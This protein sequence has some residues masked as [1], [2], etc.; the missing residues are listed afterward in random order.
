MDLGL[1][2][3]FFL[4]FFTSI[5][6]QPETCNQTSSE[7]SAWSPYLH[8]V[9]LGVQLDKKAHC[10]GKSAE[11]ALRKNPTS[12]ERFILFANQTF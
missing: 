12:L 6:K 2:V 8:F 7:D 11:M 3:G 5:I 4:R 1:N 10:F 9:L